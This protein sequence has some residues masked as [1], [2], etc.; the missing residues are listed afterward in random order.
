[1][2]HPPP[3][4]AH[5]FPWRH[6]TGNVRDKQADRCSPMSTQLVCAVSVWRHHGTLR[7]R[8]RWVSWETLRGPDMAGDHAV[9]WGKK[10]QLEEEN[11]SYSSPVQ[12]GCVPLG[13]DWFSSGSGSGFEWGPEFSECPSST[14]PFSLGQSEDESFTLLFSLFVLV[15]FVYSWH[16]LGRC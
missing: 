14:P 16:A 3:A 6:Y 9:G 8:W 11:S 15:A 13:T 5:P 10:G 1:M 12:G 4:T 2:H 7:S